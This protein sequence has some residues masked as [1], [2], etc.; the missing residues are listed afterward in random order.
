MIVACPL[1]ATVEFLG[2]KLEPYPLF[3]WIFNFLV[4]ES[5]YSL[6]KIK[7]LHPKILVLSLNLDFIFSN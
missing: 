7:L 4:F 5:I 6:A 1:D 2:G 3:T